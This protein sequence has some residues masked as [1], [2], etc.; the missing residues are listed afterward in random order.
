MIAEWLRTLG[1]LPEDLSS[2]P[3]IHHGS[4]QLSVMPI[5]G[6]PRP[7]LCGEQTIMQAKHTYLG[8]I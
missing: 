5:S 6:D 1:A 3:S 8:N 7:S 4:A 2:I